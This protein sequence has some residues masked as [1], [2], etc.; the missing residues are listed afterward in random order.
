MAEE[1]L[2]EANGYWCKEIAAFNASGVTLR[3]WCREHGYSVWRFY[4]WRNKL[5]HYAEVAPASA[6]TELKLTGD[7]EPRPVL[8]TVAR[9]ELHFS[10][11]TR[12]LFPEQFDLT[13]LRPLI[14]SLRDGSC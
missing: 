1:Q 2:V 7:A 11:G 5:R 12:L 9:L 10:C 14:A 8:E 3:Q 6:F 13:R 4:Y